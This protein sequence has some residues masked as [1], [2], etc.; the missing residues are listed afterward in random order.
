LSIQIVSGILALVVGFI[1][2]STL[3]APSGGESPFGWP[4][5]EDRLVFIAPMLCVALPLLIRAVT[6]KRPMMA[7]WF[8]AIAPALGWVNIIALMA[9]KVVFDPVGP[10]SSSASI[11]AAAVWFIPLGFILVRWRDSTTPQ[12]SPGPD[13]PRP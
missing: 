5:L 3:F 9:L 10:S 11:A 12:G 2:W 1:G 4:R 7:F 6:Q 8:V 13:A